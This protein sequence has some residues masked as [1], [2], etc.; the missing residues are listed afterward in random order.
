MSAALF[1]VLIGIAFLFLFFQGKERI[2]SKLKKEA[3]VACYEEILEWYLPGLAYDASGS[4]KMTA[5]EWLLR[6][7]FP[8]G[9]E[10]W[11]GEDYQTQ[12]ESMLSYEMILAREAA[13]ENYVDEAT[14]KLVE[15]DDGSTASADGET[16]YPADGGQ[17][18]PAD[19]GLV[20]VEDGGQTSA[21][22]SEERRV[23][24]ECRL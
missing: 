3:A 17:T 4:E 16:G 22:R 12:V 24:K 13:D 10:A 9:D 7:M 1:L 21:D 5:A 20:P 2:F 23:G 8:L 19:D 15:A 11:Y 18:L 6:H 14:G